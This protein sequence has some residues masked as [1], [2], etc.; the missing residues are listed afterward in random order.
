MFALLRNRDFGLLWLAGLI[1]LAGS[2]ALVV[3]LPLHIYQLTD[4][5]LATAGTFA[6]SF[7]PRVLFG[8]IAGV[9]VDRWDRR[10][11]MIVAD[12]SRALL[13]LSILAAPDRLELLYAVAAIQGAIGLFFSPAE[14]ALLPLLVGEDRLIA[15]NALNALND[16]IG[17]LLGPALGSMIYAGPG[18]TGVALIDAATFALS[19]LLVSRIST[20]PRPTPERPHGDAQLGTAWTRM[21]RDWRDGLGIVHRSRSLMVIFTTSSLNGIAEGVFLTLGLTPLVLDV[22]KGTPA[23]VGWLGTAQAVGGLT[24]G[25][26]VARMGQRLS[27]RWLFGGGSAL[28]GLTDTAAFNARLLTGP[29]T[30]AVGVAMGW[31]A[32]SG[33][34][35]VTMQ[36][37]KQTMLQTLVADTFRGRV[38]GALGTVQGLTMMIGLAIGG[39]LGE[40]FSIVMLL[41][42]AAMLRVVGGLI[43]LIWLPQDEQQI[44]VIESPTTAEDTDLLLVSDQV[45]GPLP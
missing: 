37:G 18:I 14:S 42:A 41:S 34:P 1:S 10:R 4:S 36:T 31:M 43:A 2:L 35:V 12:I 45:A 19:A 15:A 8:S 17:M 30:P 40:R 3:A 22:L 33:F 6:A 13:L 20:R 38:F 27:Q 32:F 25:L 5:T 21:V 29:G 39:L 24:A 16:N 7:L 28:L 23:Q 44:D 26:I 11:V 9:F